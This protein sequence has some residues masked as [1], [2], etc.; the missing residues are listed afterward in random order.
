MLAIPIAALLLAL[1]SCA[2]FTLYGVMQGEIPGGT[3]QIS[4]L[5]VTMGVGA[6]CDFL[7]SG[8]SPPYSF[9]VVSGSGSIDAGSGLYT[10]PD[11]PDSAIIQVLD[12]K[13]TTS[14]ATVTV[15]N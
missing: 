11:L 5:A 9:A 12:S 10:A 4:P 7:A 2:D 6:T 13:G 15:L 3:L 14:Q 1:A 8:G